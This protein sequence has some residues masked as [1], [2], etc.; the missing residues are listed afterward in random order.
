MGESD[1]LEQ[2]R[3]GDAK[4]YI[5]PAWRIKISYQIIRRHTKLKLIVFLNV[6]ST[7]NKNEGF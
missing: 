7:E 2:C 4:V 5:T 1:V 6:K 3:G